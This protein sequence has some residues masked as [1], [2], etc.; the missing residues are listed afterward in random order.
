VPPCSELPATQCSQYFH[1]VQLANL[2][3]G[4][5]YFY[6]IP[7]GNGT[8]PSNVMSFKTANAAGDDRSF[9]VAVINDMGYTNAKG[10]HQYL[11]EAVEQGTAFVWHGGD[12]SYADNWLNPLSPCQANETLTTCYNGTSST[13]ENPAFPNGV[14][15]PDYYIPLP[16][17][18]KASDSDPWG[19]DSSTIYENN[20]DIWQQWMN[21][22]SNYV[23]YMVAPGNHETA[24]LEGDNANGNAA[25]ILIDDLTAGSNDTKKLNYYSCPASQR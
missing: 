17:G 5:T 9:T 11:T 13:G 23:P 4:T 8:Y 14:D 10:T 21:S 7:G 16:A 22:V 2:Q 25:A 18:E 15:N 6:Q 24:C 12:I 19:G 1:E 20:W 3:P